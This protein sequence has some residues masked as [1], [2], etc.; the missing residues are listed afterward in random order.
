MP[1]SQ[2]GMSM[3]N[4]AVTIP[5]SAAAKIGSALVHADELTSP[6][7]HQFDHA[8]LAVLL[9]DPEVTSFLRLLGPLVPK[10]R[11]Q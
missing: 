9:Q 4:G 10:K 2:V 3:F 1:K 6:D 7:G 8:A 11:K 5:V